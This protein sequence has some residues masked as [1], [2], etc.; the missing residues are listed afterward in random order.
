MKNYQ[1]KFITY[2]TALSLA[3]LGM[4][5]P[6]MKK[7]ADKMISK[8][9]SSQ[10]IKHDHKLAIKASQ[11]NNIVSN[12]FNY[13]SMMSF[14]INKRTG[15]ENFSI[16]LAHFSG[17]TAYPFSLALNYNQMQKGRYYLPSLPGKGWGLALPYVDTSV[18]PVLLHLAN[19]SSYQYLGD[20]NSGSNLKYY[21][22]KNLRF[23]EA[24]AKTPITNPC[25]PSDTS[26]YALININGDETYFNHLGDVQ[27]MVNKEQ[28]SIRFNWDDVNGNIDLTNSNGQTIEITNDDGA[29]YILQPGY[30]VPSNGG[31]TYQAPHVMKL[32]NNN[33]EF[34]IAQYYQSPQSPSTL[35]TNAEIVD[36]NAQGIV[37]SIDYDMDNSTKKE[38][39]FTPKT[40]SYGNNQSFTY[41]NKVA[42][43]DGNGSLLMNPSYYNI[44]VDADNDNTFIGDIQSSV[45][46]TLTTDCVLT[47][48]DGT[49]YTYTTQTA[50]PNPKGEGDIVT[51][52]TYNHAHLLISSKSYT[53]LNTQ[54]PF[55]LGHQITD[56]EYWYAGQCHNIY[57]KENGQEIQK[58]IC[59]NQAYEPDYDT[60]SQ[61]ANYQSPVRI[62]S[63][64]F[65]L[66]SD[67]T[68]QYP[69]QPG[70]NTTVQ[71]MQYND[72]GQKTAVT[73]LNGK[74]QL[75]QTKAF[76]YDDP[77]SGDMDLNNQDY[78]L[79]TKEVTT[80]YN[81]D[82][83]KG[84]I[85]QIKTIQQVINQLTLD[86]RQVQSTTKF[87]CATQG[88][89]NSCLPKAQKVTSYTYEPVYEKDG[90][91]LNPLRGLP[92]TQTYTW[93]AGD[94]EKHQLN[95]VTTS[96]QYLG[97]SGQPL[98][99]TVNYKVYSGA[100]N[101][102][103]Q[104]VTYPNVSEVLSMQDN[105]NS[106]PSI[107]YINNV[108]GK[109]IESGTDV[110]SL[111]IFVHFD[112]PNETPQ[113]LTQATMTSD[114]YDSLGRL[115][116]KTL[117]NGQALYIQYA[118]DGSSLS[119]YGDLSAAK[120][121]SKNKKAS[122][123]A[124]F[125]I[126]STPI[127][128]INVDGLGRT[129]SVYV[130]DN[131]A[132][133]VF[134][135]IAD[136][137]QS[138]DSYS[139]STGELVTQTSYLANSPLVVN[140]YQY[141]S[142]GRKLSVT[143]TCS[144]NLVCGNATYVWHSDYQNAPVSTHA[145]DSNDI[146][147]SYF[148]ENW[149]S[150]LGSKRPSDGVN[151]VSTVKYNSLGEVTSKKVSALDTMNAIG[152]TQM[153]VAYQYN[154]LGRVIAETQAGKTANYSY[155][156]AGQVSLEN[157]VD[158]EQEL[159]T[160]E[161]K[162]KLVVK[163][164]PNVTVKSF[165]NLLGQQITSEKENDVYASSTK[166]VYISPLHIYN[167][168]GELL[169]V[170][171]YKDPANAAVDLANVTTG[172]TAQTCN[173]TVF[174]CAHMVSYSYNK[175]GQV[176]QVHSWG[177]INHWSFYNT[178]GQKI[179]ACYT[180]NN[181]GLGEYGCY[182]DDAYGQVNYFYYPQDAG[183]YAGELW[184]I[185]GTPNMKKGD[186]SHLVE[187][188]IVYTYYPDGELKSLSYPVPGSHNSEHK[189]MHYQYGAAGNEIAVTT[190]NGDTIN[191]AYQF[192]NGQWLIKNATQMHAK[193]IA[194]KVDYSYYSSGR[195][196]N[197][198]VTTNGLTTNTV[199]TYTALG[200]LYQQQRVIN[201]PKA[202]AHNLT[203]TYSYYPSGDLKT[204][205]L[206]ANFCLNNPKDM[207]CTPDITKT[208]SYVT[209]ALLN[210]K[211][212]GANSVQPQN[213]FEYNASGNLNNVSTED[214][215]TTAK[216]Y[217]YNNLNQITGINNTQ[218]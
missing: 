44:N 18:Y 14:S 54:P 23:I 189:T 171:P 85:G 48:A 184:M 201:M 10:V 84:S 124:G 107:S 195:L 150:I 199:D 110:T 75:V 41:I 204:K 197:T 198:A 5:M 104:S 9:P 144:N 177:G 87:Y 131:V 142:M 112:K 39:F 62:E 73:I 166:N 74:G 117:P 101:W 137:E 47:G 215:G 186:P 174:D 13:K 192:I 83:T 126:S 179:D 7:N 32:S 130:N 116:D 165:Y 119:E 127:K 21:S 167:N 148:V 210:V 149:E 64:V 55:T 51:L 20:N 218:S 108:N 208:Y 143:Q 28:Q 90:K 102:A 4:A 181:D 105:S 207:S 8:D 164:A 211:E 38:V 182:R 209:G 88:G 180:K 95:A 25:D 145:L 57:V 15:T 93:P 26:Q 45:C 82:A 106:Y 168:L 29:L 66:P 50:S 40:F 214:N 58:Q 6:Q 68:A 67:G 1:A 92:L 115:V 78:G 70:S 35:I 16:P 188:N 154:N 12:A 37:T 59:G 193:S 156:A 31:G 99:Q 173:A 129:T 36:Y 128:Q 56:S 155:N 205:E 125:E 157:L 213:T 98:T 136:I 97:L 111:P 169:A 11:K 123:T 100:G 24:S 187:G 91:T 200:R 33:N 52:K 103:T 141:D 27:C 146:K 89:Q 191:Y 161:L 43:D 76:Y 63:T 77:S 175:F 176:Y 170:V 22:L 135:P 134:D 152:N 118:T 133:G 153:S 190:Y 120:S 65:N 30:K 172:L 194:G 178:Q 140:S 19:G 206:Q 163:N 49:S 121:K 216:Y 212:S 114:L 147:H 17:Q 86:N 196:D 185:A 159:S 71:E 34:D 203:N 151:V 2:I 183:A 202:A 217:T 3:H 109:V 53:S 80:S 42:I 113:E 81:T 94:T 160:P 138:S 79:L 60:L 158:T 132:Y 162:S 69:Y 96:Y 139:S 72:F 122:D 61:R 46:N